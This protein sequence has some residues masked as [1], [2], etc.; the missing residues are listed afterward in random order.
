MEGAVGLNVLEAK[1]AQAFGLEVSERQALMPLN[2]LEERLEAS[3]GWWVGRTWSSRCK[4]R[5]SC[6]WA[7]WVASRLV[8]GVQPR[9]AV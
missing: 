4:W 1:A 6:C 2:S 5:T 7:C 3:Q 9:A 8:G